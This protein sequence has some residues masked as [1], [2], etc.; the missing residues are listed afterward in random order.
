MLY[1]C[2]MLSYLH[3]F[4]QWMI[5]V[6]FYCWSLFTGACAN[7]LMGLSGLVNIKPRTRDKSWLWVTVW[8]ATSLGVCAEVAVELWPVG[9]S[10]SHVASHPGDGVPSQDGGPH[11]QL[12]SWRNVMLFEKF[13]QHRIISYI[14]EVKKKIY[15][16]APNW[17]MSN[18]GD[19]I[20]L[21]S[22]FFLKKDQ[23]D[24]CVYICVLWADLINVNNTWVFWVRAAHW[25]M[26]VCTVVCYVPAA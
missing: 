18:H 11:W 14:P 7:F 1:H 23:D 24:L 9:W 15:G 20:S 12:W 16:N 5:A 26:L 17:I 13:V 6:L 10:P 4:T 3:T 19:K 25:F 21:N 8:T 22:F 2:Q